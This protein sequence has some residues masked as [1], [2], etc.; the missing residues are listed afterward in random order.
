MS[1][2][3]RF[4]RDAEDDLRRLYA[5]QLERG[6]EVAE[7][8][9][10]TIIKSMDLLREFPFSCRKA[11]V[12]N[13]FLRELLITFG[14]SGYVALYEIENDNTVTIVAVRHQLEDDYH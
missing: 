12:D 5:F 3:L 9:L 4:A 8:S 6:V 1:Y 2:Q 13:P 11:L 14:S 7:R 10:Q